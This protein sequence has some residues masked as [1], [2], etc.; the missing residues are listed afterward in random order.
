MGSADSS[1]FQLTLQAVQRVRTDALAGDRPLIERLELASGWTAEQFVAALGALTGYPVMT[2]A[3]LHAGRLAF[4]VLPFPAA[5]KHACL[6]FVDVH[7]SLCCV[8]GD[9]FDDGLRSWVEQRIARQFEW[10]LAHPSDIA[11]AFKRHEESARALDQMAELGEDADTGEDG[12]PQLTLK[13]IS[14][15]ESP[16]VKLVNSMMYDALVAGASDIHLETT[17]GG[18]KIKYRLDGVLAEMR[19]V[20]GQQVAEEV[21]SRIKYVARADISERRKPQD[22]RFNVPAEGRKVDIRVSIIPSIHGENAVLRILDKKALAD[23][24]KGLRLDALGFEPDQVLQ[25]RHLAREAYG[26]LLVTGPTGSGK[27]TTLYATVSE[28]N[29]GV[30]KI[31]TIEDPVEY[32]L[33]GV[34]QIQVDE[35][36]ELT[37]AKGLRSILRHDPDK[38]LV[39]EIRD[40]ETAQIAIQAALT[41]HLVFSTV[42]ANNAF[43]VLARLIH[44]GVEPYNIISAM[45]AIVAQRLIR[46]VCVHCAV[47]DTPSA[48]LIA[49]SK[50]APAALPAFVFK[51]G[52]GCGHCRGTGF[53]GRK[54]VA[55]VLLLTDELRELV[56][57]RVSVRE[58]RIAAARNGMRELREAALDVVRRGETTLGEINRVTLAH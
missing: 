4:D 52:L 36:K 51:K 1:A 7:G 32:Q 37:F 45:N 5:S 38:I 56:I 3:D 54:A 57:Q 23:E 15:D 30:D 46:K 17:P 22:G 35:D 13:N 42:H 27:S 44:M 18:L 53:R 28:I 11:A 34:T 24:I 25:I 48:E 55:E 8:L 12:A 41:G 31:I 9:P 2:M 50:V 6:P 19:T 26:M 33:P 29:T 40:P 21:I 47:P 49:E 58:L 39:G 10:R 43:D 16:V 20:S 14:A